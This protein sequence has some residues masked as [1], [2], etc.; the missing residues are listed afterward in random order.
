MAS[1][2]RKQ[3]AEEFPFAVTLRFK[4]EAE[5]QDF[6]GGLSD[7]WGENVCSLH[8]SW[9]D[10][11]FHEAEMFGVDLEDEYRRRSAPSESDPR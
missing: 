5:K 4:S 1:K 10:V 9:P 11:G 6:M 2:T 8:W 7:G 3:I